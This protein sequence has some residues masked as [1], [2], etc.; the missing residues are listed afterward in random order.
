MRGDPLVIFETVVGSRAYGLAG[1]DSDT[2]VKGVGIGPASWYH[3]WRG[4]P[5]LIT[6][7]PDHVRYECRRYLGL[8]VAANPT[9]LEMAWTRPEDQLTTHPLGA[10][11]LAA[12]HQFLSKRVAE[13]FGRYAFSQLKRIKTHRSWL[14][15]PPSGPP[16]RQQF[17]LPERTLIPSDQLAAAESLFDQGRMEEADVSANFIDVLVRERR[18]KSAQKHWAMYRRWQ[19]ERNPARAELERRYG[20]DTKHAMHLVRLQRMALEVLTTGRVVVFRPDRE[21]LL[22]IRAGAW[23]FDQ[24]EASAGD[25]AD[26]I[27]AAAETS[28]L[29]P[30]PDEDAI[31]QLCASI[32]AEALA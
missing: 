2:D 7:S 17:G 13:R 29:P 6:R 26:R 4:G 8:C 27:T 19:Q 28:H 22:A 21:E 24:L 25:L 9:T 3:G 5:E 12:R 30:E 32:I 20:Y 10:R 14:L 15:S 11:L 23:S 18:Y 1:P 16:L 31:D